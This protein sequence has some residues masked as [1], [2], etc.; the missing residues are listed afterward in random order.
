MFT[1]I[2]HLDVNKLKKIMTIIK[3]NNNQIISRILKSSSIDS[4]LVYKAKSYLT[5]Q[6][7]FKPGYIHLY[8]IFN[9]LIQKIIGT[10]QLYKTQLHMISLS[11]HENQSEA[12]NVITKTLI[13]LLIDGK[14]IIDHS[15]ENII[16]KIYMMYPTQNV[17][18]VLLSI[19][20]ITFT[21]EIILKYG[22]SYKNERLTEFHKICN[23]LWKQYVNSFELDKCIILSA[24]D[25]YT[26][27]N[28][29]IKY[30]MGETAMMQYK[31]IIRIQQLI[32]NKRYGLEQINDFLT[33]HIYDIYLQLND[34]IEKR[35]ISSDRYRSRVYI[36]MRLLELFC[37]LIS[38]HVNDLD[39]NN[40]DVI[41][42]YTQV[43]LLSHKKKLNN[44]WKCNYNE[45]KIKL[46]KENNDGLIDKRRTKSLNDITKT[47][48]TNKRLKIHV[49]SGSISPKA[50][51]Y[52]IE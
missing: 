6:S 41:L 34:C 36:F 1:N 46:L 26:I 35:D 33:I 42:N 22:K 18:E 13:Q 47:G 2:E 21:D 43:D 38:S 37:S 3:C 20:C 24:E 28:L 40:I 29:T 30:G 32:S 31:K 25:L 52:K 19:L 44:I 9:P 10:I 7:I 45:D 8:D 50:T 17:T 4:N 5:D 12:I 14:I 15:L 49:R 51:L 48:L 23:H 16:Q 39:P 11:L 27:N